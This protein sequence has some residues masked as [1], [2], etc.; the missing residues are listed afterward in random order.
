MNKQRRFI[1]ILMTRINFPKPKLDYLHC[2]KYQR[3]FSALFQAE[4]AKKG[5]HCR[6]KDEHCS[7]EQ[8]LVIF[9]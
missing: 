1:S 6:E 4:N 8:K 3:T 7:I 9:T 5:S 2:E